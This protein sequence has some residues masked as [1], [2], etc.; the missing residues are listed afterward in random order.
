M[1]HPAILAGAFVAIVYGTLLFTTG[2]SLFWL[3]AL[4][5]VLVGGFEVLLFGPGPAK[6]GGVLAVVAGLYPA[7]SVGLGYGLPPTLGA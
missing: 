6:V 7:L 2:V 3:L 4:D 1:P 5:T